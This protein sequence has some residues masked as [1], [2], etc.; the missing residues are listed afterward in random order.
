MHEDCDY[1]C[2]VT[3]LGR[4]S[5]LYLVRASAAVLFFAKEEGTQGKV[6]CRN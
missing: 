1:K 4:Y 6:D 3:S 2:Y 5:G